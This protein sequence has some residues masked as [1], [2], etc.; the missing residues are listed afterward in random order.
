MLESW[1]IVW[2]KGFVPFLTTAG[3]ESLQK[4]LQA[5]DPRL[6]QGCTT[7][8]P[9]LQ[10]VQDWPVNA[11][12]ALGFCGWQGEGLNTVAEVEKY[13]A[14]TCFQIDQH[15]GEPAAC[16]WF[17]NWFDDTPREEMRRELLAEVN[18]ALVQRSQEPS[19]TS[20]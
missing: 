6:I 19:A 4:A 13:F 15:L 3:L 10:C 5:D 16:R 18:L 17:V 20:A 14:E 11:A 7:T 1:R 9:P 12:C 2:R 8:P